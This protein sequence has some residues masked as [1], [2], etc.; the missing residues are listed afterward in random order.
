MAQGL[1]IKTTVVGG[2][3][4]VALI[5]QL[6]GGIWQYNNRSEARR[7]E[8]RH[9]NEA[10]LL[11]VTDLA[12]R[13]VEGGNQMILSDAAATSLYQASK[14]HYLKVTGT[15]AGAEKTAFTEAIPPQPIAHEFI[16]KNAD[17][18]RLAAL[19]GATKETGFLEDQ[20]LFVVRM[21]LKQVKN[22]GELVAV[23]PADQLRSIRLDTLREGAPLAMSILTLS[24]LLAWFI[25]GRI[26]S[27]VTRLSGQIGEIAGNLDLSRRISLSSQDTAFNKEAGIMAQAFNTLRDNLHSTLTQVRGNTTQVSNAVTH[28][29]GSSQ[30]VAQRSEQQSSAAAAMASAMEEMTAN[31][32]E[33]A[34]NANYVDRASRESGERSR[35][36]GSIIGRATDEMGAIAQT[37]HAGSTSIEGLGK[38]SQQISAIVQVI[39]DIADQTNLLALNAAIEAAR[40]GEAGRGCAVVADEV[41]K[42]AERTAQSTQQ[43][44]SMITA[45]QGSAADAVKIMEDTVQRVSAGVSLADQAGTAI[46]Q[47]TLSADHV[48]KGVA[49]IAAALQQQGLAGQ[50]MSRHVEDIAGMTEENSH[51]ASQTA[52]AARDLEA[53]AADMRQA[54]D[55]FRL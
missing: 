4:G 22:K 18:A 17:G 32:A 6:V 8:I 45:I 19:A 51:T 2:I 28:L 5:S 52:Q 37:V 13:G 41:R 36:G 35:L 14:V 11:A 27:P 24:I 12:A 49:E 21:P 31:L 16:A 55:R 30:Q 23:F 50:D 25:G 48:V 3:A 47:I 38:Q 34:S 39:R 9:I 20:Y 15:S 1:S 53:L 43:I 54:V 44:G 29:A 33:I 46:T 26:A 42:L 40:A 7:Q 10:A